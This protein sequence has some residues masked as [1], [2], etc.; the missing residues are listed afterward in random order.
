[1]SSLPADPVLYLALVNSAAKDALWLARQFERGTPENDLHFARCKALYAAKADAAARLA[2]L[3][4][5]KLGLHDTSRIRPAALLIGH[6]PVL[7][8]HA[9]HLPVP[10]HAWA[11]HLSRTRIRILPGSRDRLSAA[12]RSAPPVDDMLTAL[13]ALAALPPLPRR[14]ARDWGFEAPRR[15]WREIET[16]R[17][18]AP[19]GVPRQRRTRK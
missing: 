3:G 19:G 1:M 17:A 16:A 2:Y 10:P 4:V 14:V 5:L 11:L 12:K 15:T 13:A 18:C 9:F 6:S 8:N 7:G